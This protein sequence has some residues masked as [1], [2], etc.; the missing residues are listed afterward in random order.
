M[1]IDYMKER[2]GYESLEEEWGFALFNSA[3]P[4]LFLQ[5]LYVKPELRGSHKG[6]RFVD[7]LIQIAKE[8]QC[9]VIQAQVWLNDRNHENTLKAGFKTGFKMTACGD[10]VIIIS[11][12]V[13]EA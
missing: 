6:T 7:R 10:N 4:I 2:F 3:P 1:W 13:G 12:S 11:K 9:S 8:R 5:D